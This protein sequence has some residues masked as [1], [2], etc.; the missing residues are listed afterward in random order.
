MTDEIARSIADQIDNAEVIDVGTDEDPPGIGTP[1]PDGDFGDDGAGEAGLE[2]VKGPVARKR[3]SGEEAARARKLGYSVD[4][5]NREFALVLLGSKAVVY[6]EQPD[7]PVEDQQRILSLEAFNAWFR[8]RYTET[9]GADGKVKAVTWSTAWM[10]DRERRSY[11]G[12]EFWPMTGVNDASGRAGYLNLW[13]GWAV[14]PAPK[15]NGYAVFRD[16]MLTNVCRGDEK[17]F[18]WVFAFFAHMVQ[19]PR[20]R[21]GVAIVMRGVMGSGKTKVGEVFGSLCPRHYFLVDDP[22]YVVG[23][24]NAHMASCLLLQ[25]D[26]AVWAGDKA[27][28]GRLKGLVTSPI[29]Q[30]EAK[31]VDPIRLMN[32]VRLIMTSNEDWVVPAGKDERRFCVLDI[33]PRCAQQHEY[34]REMDEELNRGG[35]EALLADLLDFDLDSVNLRKIPR[36]GALLEQKIRSFD[37]VEMWWYEALQRGAIV[38]DG[39]AWPSAVQKSQLVDDYIAAAERIG[40]KRKAA[41]TE[42][43]MKLAKLVPGLR[44]EKVTVY[45]DAGISRRRHCFILPPL[46]NCREAYAEAL[47][48]PVD[49]PES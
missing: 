6:M 36:T 18:R 8:N 17:L 48:Q 42:L 47:Q 35:R 4:D 37:S 43:G 33:D 16:H 30:I 34:F 28:E 15:L 24:F 40:I 1:P 14:Q 26:E 22:R 32:F 2:G 38:R 11:R 41:E 29:Q 46:E 44:S 13:S 31:G 12:I 27:A 10:S 20:E 5:I 7:A 39:E 25:A 9:R 19:R 49:W 21:L 23:Q 45:D 3:A